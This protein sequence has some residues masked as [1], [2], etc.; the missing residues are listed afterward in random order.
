MPTIATL[1]VATLSACGAGQNSQQPDGESLGRDRGG[2]LAARE[3]VPAIPPRDP[4]AAEDEAP[5]APADQGPITERVTCGRLQAEGALAED[6]LWRSLMHLQRSWVRCIP[7]N[8]QAHFVAILRIH[9]DG[10]S[11]TNIE[12]ATDVPAGTCLA[13]VFD[14]VRFPPSADETTVR[15]AVRVLRANDVEQDCVARMDTP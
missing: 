6:T 3:P 1:L 5:I 2:G 12:G 13:T 9:R 10:A 8:E 15:L 14:N 4:N 7:Q 11:D